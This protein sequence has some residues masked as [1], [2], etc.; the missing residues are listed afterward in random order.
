MILS[1]LYFRFNNKT[2]LIMHECI[3]NKQRKPIIC[4]YCEKSYA[5]PDKLKDHCATAHPDRPVPK[6]PN[7]VPEQQPKARERVPKAERPVTDRDFRV[8]DGEYKCPKCPR[9]YKTLVQARTHHTVIHSKNVRCEYCPAKYNDRK[10]L[11]QHMFRKH[12]N[13]PMPKDQVIANPFVMSS[14]SH[15]PADPTEDPL[16]LPANP[17][18]AASNGLDVL[19]PLKL[20]DGSIRCPLCPKTYTSAGGFWIHKRNCHPQWFNVTSKSAARSPAP[21]AA[22]QP[23]P[24]NQKFRCDLCGKVYASYASLYHHRK[25]LHPHTMKKGSGSGSS[26]PALMQ[27]AL[28]DYR[29]LARLAPKPSPMVV[30]VGGGGVSHTCLK[31]GK[32]FH[33]LKDLAMH[34]EQKHQMGGPNSELM[35]IENPLI[36]NAFGEVDISMVANGATNADGSPRKY[37]EKCYKCPQ[38]GKAYNDAE[39]LKNHIHDRHTANFFDDIEP[40]TDVV[41]KNHHSKLGYEIYKIL[42]VYT[43]GMRMKGVKL[44]YDPAEKNWRLT[45]QIDKHVSKRDVVMILTTL[46]RCGEKRYKMD[47]K[48]YMKMTTTVNRVYMEEKSLGDSNANDD[49]EN[50]GDDPLAMTGNT[51][52]VIRHSGSMNG[53]A[54]GA[55]RYSAEDN[56]DFEDENDVEDVGEEGEEDSEDGESGKINFIDICAS[57]YI[58]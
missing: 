17:S 56:D 7:V 13:Q 20:P 46:K 53:G 15:P 36:N 42:C 45:E 47:D 1:F 38:C 27:A 34:I 55:R 48:E 51:T 8:I 57:D 3:H 37:R 11:Y 29:N 24:S 31:C 33:S 44:K 35:A 30:N 32:P 22:E 39:R 50:S 9:M 19:Q 49:D 5:R 26:S 43:T 2:K 52:S 28:Q 21:R 6:V 54:A 23:Q 18:P 10:G 25:T 41:V 14:L 58:Y 4:P 16:A 40:N 12:P